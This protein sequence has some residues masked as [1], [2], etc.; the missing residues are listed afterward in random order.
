ML[1]K[2][3]HMG[4]KCV[5]G[6]A[7]YEE[8]EWVKEEDMGDDVIVKCVSPL[9]NGEG[10][11][12]AG[13]IDPTENALQNKQ[14]PFPSIPR[15]ISSNTTIRFTTYLPPCQAKKYRSPLPLSTSAK[16]SKPVNQLSSL[17]HLPHLPA[18]KNPHPIPKTHT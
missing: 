4:S 9:Q 5:G 11:K 18:T 10:G 8:W 3:M 16:R 6:S 2:E 17:S 14:R 15:A 1:K 12:R 13:N 7:A